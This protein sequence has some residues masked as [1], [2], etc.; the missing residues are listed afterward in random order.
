MNI[1][2]LEILQP[3]PLA[4][5]GQEVLRRSQA[6]TTGAE[7]ARHL[8]KWEQEWSGMAS[9]AATH[10]AQASINPIDILGMTA[11]GVGGVFF[12]HG[13]LLEAICAVVRGSLALARH[14]G[15]LV[16]AD[17]TVTPGPAAAIPGIN[18]WAVSTAQALS[19]V[20]HG[21]LKFVR[22]ADTA[23]TG[24][25]RI[26]ISGIGD[27]PQVSG[28]GSSGASEIEKVEAREE[29][30]PFGKVRTYGSLE[31][32]DK[33]ITLVSGVGSSGEESQAKTDLWARQ[34]VAEAQAEGKKVAVVT[35]HG[36]PAPGNITEA[37]SPS[38]ATAAAGDFRDFQRELRGRAP[39]AELHV[40]GY[41]YGSTVVGLAGKASQG[42]LE[43]DR[44]TLWGSPGAGV[45]KAEEIN[46]IRRGSLI[47]ED[48]VVERGRSQDSPQTVA[49]LNS[50]RVPGD[51]IGLATTP[52]GSPLGPDPTAPPFNSS[53]WF[54]SSSLFGSTP[55]LSSS[56]SLGASSSSNQP[57]NNSSGAGWGEYLWR[58]LTDMYLWSRGETDSHSS[59]LWDPVVNTRL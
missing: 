27:V 50:E 54:S 33:V 56:P 42:G 6:L 11:H 5:A 9:A 46:L 48:S 39:K 19:T 43:A 13:K 29:Q 14:S 8:T 44:M 16:G 22:A 2:E 37:V 36:Y 4:H 3:A 25:I 1:Y 30:N 24:A 18:T 21:A 47:K 53:S 55:S 32:A 35:W 26:A 28:V 45:R 51:L 23:A 10:R 58:E 40:V 49:H 20:L 12:A 34:K 38:A 7:K 59:Y 31:A 52:L 17:G 41:S 15:M 57:E